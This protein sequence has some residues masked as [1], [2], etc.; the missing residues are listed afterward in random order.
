MEQDGKLEQAYGLGQGGKLGLVY[1]LAQRD[2]QA[3]VLGLD[4]KELACVL[5]LELRNLRKKRLRCIQHSDQRCI[6][7][8]VFCHQEEAH[9]NRH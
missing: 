4:D 1:E 5:E 9:C 6:L 3:C 8:S 2:K 7:H